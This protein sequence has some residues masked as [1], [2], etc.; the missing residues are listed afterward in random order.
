M[1]DLASQPAA[2]N[3]LQTEKLWR[4]AI[5]R[6]QIKVNKRLDALRIAAKS[7]DM[8]GAKDHRDWLLTA[9]P[10]KRIAIAQLLRAGKPVQVG[11][12]PEAKAL[13][14]TVTLAEVMDDP[15]LVFAREKT[16]KN[17]YRAIF[18]FGDRHKV[19]HR[20]LADVI[21]AQT[22]TRRFQLFDV[23]V[24][25][26]IG[27]VLAKIDEGNIWLAHLDIRNFFPSFTMDGLTQFLPL[28]T[29]AVETALT[30]RNMV[31]RTAPLPWSYPYCP[32]HLI[33]EARRGLPQ[34]AASSPAVS[35]LCV[36]QLALPAADL[37]LLFNYED[38]FLVLAMT[39]AE[40]KARITRL[41]EAVGNLPGGHF[42]LSVKTI[43]SAKDG[44]DF[45]GHRLLV[46]KG[47]AVAEPS[48]LNADRLAARLNQIEEGAGIHDPATSSPLSVRMQVYADQLAVLAGWKAAFA[49]CDK[50]SENWRWA[51]GEENTIT[52]MLST[53]GIAP[54]ELPP[55]TASAKIRGQTFFYY[56]WFG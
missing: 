7:G 34:G 42:T 51:V 23:G 31:L 36:A 9:E 47:K 4:K 35:H 46:R 33:E 11:S 18:T 49:I 53:M 13:A 5:Q 37:E 32:S 10:A 56:K 15:A 54:H 6:D 40:L 52:A 27:R 39:E 16:S 2:L 24:P 45:L 19:G 14:E 28:P 50:A 25:K 22:F 29:A 8:A 21:E 44:L 55:P 43:A 26:A 3:I 1:L 30:G 17:G 12:Y 20:L 38:D 48:D 41:T